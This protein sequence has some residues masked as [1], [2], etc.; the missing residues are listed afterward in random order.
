ML[1]IVGK[2]VCHGTKHQECPG[3][4][5]PRPSAATAQQPTGKTAREHGI[6]IVLHFHYAEC[7]LMSFSRTFLFKDLFYLHLTN[8]SC[9]TKKLNNSDRLTNLVYFSWQLP[10]SLQMAS[11][12]MGFGDPLS[13]LQSVSP[14]QFLPVIALTFIDSPPSVGIHVVVQCTC[15]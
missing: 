6:D 5:D 8:S 13:P 11:L 7:M 14:T 10:N 2:E 1:S 12:S 3:Q 15:V 9:G 4:A